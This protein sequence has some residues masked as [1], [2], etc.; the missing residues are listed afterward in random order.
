MLEGVVSCSDFL[1]SVDK[2]PLAPLYV[3]YGNEDLL[4]QTALKQ[5]KKRMLGDEPQPANII[6][7]DEESEPARLFDTLRTPSLFGPAGHHLIV[8]SGGV[9][10]IKKHE[11]LIERYL[12]HPSATGSMVLL[13]TGGERENE[14]HAK[15]LAARF[16]LVIDCRTLPSYELPRYVTRMAGKVGKQIDTDAAH[17]LVGLVGSSLGQL[18]RQL[19]NLADLIKDRPRI[20]EKDVAELVGTDFQRG[21][22][23]LM[24]MI[25]EKKTRETLII[26]DR[27]LRQE[28][29]G[30]S[31]AIIGLLGAELRQI[32][33][34]KEILATGG[35]ESQAMNVLIGPR[36]IRE[37]KFSDA[38]RLPQA[39]IER[40][41]HALAE[42]DL[43]CKTSSLPVQAVLEMLLIDLCR[44][45]QRVRA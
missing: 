22:W 34:A 9:Q 11:K 1:R 38:R 10:F 14:K 45:A 29:D 25:G 5:I 15:S 39:E 2:A 40:R 44:P 33:E 13:V 36:A 41:L 18:Q 17:L 27:L 12:K 19:Q 32:A 30:E 42:A 8:V 28:G 23:D 43:K 35:S 31:M 4:A 21:V 37:R 6:E 20:T 3:I 16:G 26:L 24:R 7:A